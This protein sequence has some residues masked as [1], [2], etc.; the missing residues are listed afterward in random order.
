MT[1]MPDASGAIE[2]L[3][4]RNENGM[5]RCLICNYHTQDH[6]DWCPVPAILEAFA[7]LV[8]ERDAAKQI[9]EAMEP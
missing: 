8:Q 6:S 2:G 9:T 5:I 1:A 7:A 4:T 3:L